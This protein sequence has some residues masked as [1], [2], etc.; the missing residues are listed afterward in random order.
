MGNSERVTPLAELRYAG[1]EICTKRCDQDLTE[2]KEGGL[3]KS[4][5]RT[6]G[7]AEAKS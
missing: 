1:F 4:S 7:G 3:A 6:R 2:F 5:G